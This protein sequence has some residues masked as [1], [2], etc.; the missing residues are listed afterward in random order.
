M[1]D[2]EM[3]ISLASILHKVIIEIMDDEDK[4]RQKMQLANCDNKLGS[5]L[6][7]YMK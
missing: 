5:L 7:E 1:S 2:K 6:Y 3:V 4:F